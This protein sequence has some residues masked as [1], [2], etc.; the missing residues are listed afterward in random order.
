MSINIVE[1]INEIKLII[2]TKIDEDNLNN[3]IM[4]TNMNR[5]KERLDEVIVD[6][7]YKA[8]ENKKIVI[9]EIDQI[10]QKYLGKPD[11][12]WKKQIA[13]ILCNLKIK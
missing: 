11:T 8:H 13:E 6:Y 10:L 5:L 9:L 7:I 1:K 2:D 3:Q 4:N 12:V